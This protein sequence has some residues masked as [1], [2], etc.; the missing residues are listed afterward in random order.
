MSIKKQFLKSKPVCKI[1]FKIDKENANGAKSISV[2]G[3]FNQW[4]ETA[5]QMKALK[6]GSFSLNLDLETGN[7][8]QFRYFADGHAWLNEPEADKQFPS[9]F[10]DAQN[11]VISL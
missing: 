11:S 5:G 2:V 10:G 1:S 4:D 9:G 8:Y 6:D 7:E 3:D